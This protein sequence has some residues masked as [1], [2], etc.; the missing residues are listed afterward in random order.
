V[1]ICVRNAFHM[2]KKV[3][4]STLRTIAGRLAPGGGFSEKP[5]TPFR[6]DAT[7]WAIL[8]LKADG[9]HSDLVESARSRLAS[10]QL[11][12]GRICLSQIHTDVIWPTALVI[13]ALH[14]SVAYRKQMDQAVHFLLKTKGKFIQKRTNSIFVIDP[15]LIGWPW[16]EN[17]FSWTEPTALSILALNTC[18]Y[19]SD[20]RIH[21][22]V[23]LLMDR[24]LP[25][26][27]WNIG[28]TIIYG[29]ETYPQLDCTG[30]ALT[31][32][33]GYVDRK[34][35]DRSLRYLNSKVATCRTPL[36]LGWALFGLGAWGERPAE[37][38][39]WLLNCLS[40]QKKYGPY[41]TASLSLILLA[42]QAKGGLL[43]LIV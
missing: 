31:A 32:L 21:Q 10:E 13:L 33:Q 40:R 5:N 30:I 17:T 8:A 11:E 2:D 35:I 27:G 4:A 28:S 22:A 19:S 3:L 16:I 7:A 41:G 38:R 14:G 20:K 25:S 39:H 23:R 6:T 43:E 1:F 15:S 37:A 26:G 34:E 18:G 36:S 9:P 29:R 42:L 12:D 24:Q